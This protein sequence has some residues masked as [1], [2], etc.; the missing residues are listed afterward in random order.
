MSTYSDR[1][2]TEEELAEIRAQFYYVDEDYYGRKRL[3]FD[4]AGGSLRLKRAE[5]AFRRIDSI[6]DASEHSNSLALELAALEDRGR[7]DIKHVIFNAKSGT[8]YPTYTASQIAME[9]VRRGEIPLSRRR[10]ARMRRRNQVKI[11]ILFRWPPRKANSG[12]RRL[13]S[14]GL[15]FPLSAS[16][17][18]G[19]PPMGAHAIGSCKET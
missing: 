14:V 3:F 13:G 8:I 7:D 17:M 15:V 5:E 2:F 12:R 1:M 16:Q 18:K 9:M 4:N 6:P 11:Q 10:M 19:I